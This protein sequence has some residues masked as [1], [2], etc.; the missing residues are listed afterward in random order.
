MFLLGF[1]GFLACGLEM[2]GDAA[3]L[4]GFQSSPGSPRSAG[5]SFLAFPFMNR[6][7]FIQAA[8]LGSAALIPVSRSLAVPSPMSSHLTSPS[9]P[10]PQLAGRLLLRWSEAMLAEQIRSPGEAA[11]HGA[12]ACPACGKIHGR[13]MDAVYPFLA[14]AK[15]TGDRR[16]L[17]AGISVFEW[18]S[19]VTLPDGSWTVMPDPKSWTGITVFGAIAL[20]EA[21]HHHGDLLDA[22][23]LGRWRERL[24]QAGRFIERTFDLSFANVNYGFTGAYAMSL[25]G[26]V[27]DEPAFRRKGRELASHFA[28]FLTEPNALI[29]GEAKPT[30]RRSARGHY[31]VDLGYNV[32]E[33]LNGIALYA[34]REKD[35]DLIELVAKSM[36]AHL[37]FMLPDGGWDNSWG[38]RSFKWTYWGSRT[39]DGCQL[40]YALMADRNPVFGLAALRNAELLERC[41]SDAGL[42]YGGI[43]YAEH[44]I[45]PCIHHTFAHAKQMAA[46]LDLAPSLPPVEGLSL[47]RHQAEGIRSY[48]EVSVWTASKGAWRATVSAYDFIYRPGVHQ[49]TGGSLALLWHEKLGPLFTASLAA[50]TLVEANNQQA[51]PDGED[52]PL[53]PR[54]ETLLDDVWYTNLYD[55]AASVQASEGTESLRILV[56]TKLRNAEQASLPGHDGYQLQ[57]DIGAESVRFELR[58]RSAEADPRARFTLPLICSSK[59]SWKRLDERRVVIEKAG[60]KLLVESSEPIHI[61]TTQRDRVFNMVPGAQA[62]PLTIPLPT[63][64]GQ[65]LVCSARMIAR[66]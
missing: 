33:T 8:A 28:R 38:T 51:N 46:L 14:V 5:R 20:A 15:R 31:A 9:A 62:L 29:Y 53:T 10:L 63:V 17:E 6:R 35:S 44:G 42:L 45:Q 37:H 24:L 27:F 43:H 1:L 66:G 2:R 58:S 32:E 61:A 4:F 49:A 59:E 30:D 41:T 16:F 40:A 25:L 50:Y 11:T 65:P 48:P 52:F 12:L 64:A 57:Y 34:L 21:L 7:H 26:E 60:G 39:C 3:Y 13:C 19:N 18:S 54:L 47:P 36:E 22:A 55:L 56:D 23:T